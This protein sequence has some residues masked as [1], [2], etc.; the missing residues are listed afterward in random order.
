[1]TDQWFY[2]CNGEQKG[3]VPLTDLQR[4]AASGE[5]KPTDLVWR[6]GM[7]LW[8]PAAEA[9]S[10][11]RAPQD[12]VAAQPVPLPARVK[13]TSAV[14]QPATPLSVGP[15]PPRPAA[16]RAMRTGTK[17]ALF[18]GIAGVALLVVIVG[19]VVNYARHRS[20]VVSPAGSYVV[21]LAQNASNVRQ[22]R[23]LAG[24]RV[25]IRVTS[26]VDTDVD[27]YVFD[28]FGN[29]IAVD[30]GPDKDCMVRFHV[31]VT[32]MYDV[33]VVNVGDRFTQATV[34]YH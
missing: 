6:S 16:Q 30:D 22:V 13:P 18:G 5:L 28:R 25:T 15:R 20:A 24:S 19:L 32:G 14:E 27:L 9:R 8:I 12:E 34:E 26:A 7:H 11:F 3:P 29:Q 23:F 21:G 2:S 17:V 4:L 1:M 33:E 10:L 31:P